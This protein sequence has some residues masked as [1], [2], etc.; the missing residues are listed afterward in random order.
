MPASAAK[1]W[2]TVVCIVL[3]ATGLFLALAILQPF[4]AAYRLLLDIIFRPPDGQ[5]AALDGTV[6]FLL[7]LS[8][9]LLIGW[10]ITLYGL[11]RFPGTFGP[12]GVRRIVLPA[13]TLWF[14]VDMTGS[15]WT[16]ATLNLAVNIVLYVA[17][18]VPVLT[19]RN[20]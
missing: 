8:G 13:L 2:L 4:A 18:A 11:F 3:S 1:A 6:Q 5:P 7:A 12:A 10:S 15:W 14:V 16:G 17:V 20:D 19:F 9:A